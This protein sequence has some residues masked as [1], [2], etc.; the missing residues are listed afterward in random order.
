M[1]IFGRNK[2]VQGSSDGPQVPK[3]VNRVRVTF[4]QGNN[5]AQHDFLMEPE[6]TNQMNVAY[7]MSDK[8]G[9]GVTIHGSEIVGQENA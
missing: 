2:V 1:G 7:V 8:Y 6:H 5:T 9:R 4:S 3:R